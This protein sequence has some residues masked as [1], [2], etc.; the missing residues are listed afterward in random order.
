[1]KNKDAD[2][3][4][5][6]ATVRT[7]HA[8]REK[9]A[10]TIKAT[11]ARLA[12]VSTSALFGCLLWKGMSSVSMA[13]NATINEAM[14]DTESCAV[15]IEALLSEN[16]KAYALAVLTAFVLIIAGVAVDRLRADLE[17]RDE[18]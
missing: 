8:W 1:M 11:K 9:T 16:R 12:T 2:K 10:K 18:G 4:I 5:S 6:P 7:A 13:Q 14:S 17:A 15:V 3:A